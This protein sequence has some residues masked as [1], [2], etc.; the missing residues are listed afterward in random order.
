MCFALRFCPDPHQ[1][2]FSRKLILGSGKVLDHSH[3]CDSMLFR[4][5]WREPGVVQLPE[6]KPP[7]RPMDTQTLNFEDAMSPC[8]SS[9]PLSFC[10]LER[11]WV[12]ALHESTSLLNCTCLYNLAHFIQ[13]VRSFCSCVCIARVNRHYSYRR[14][15]LC[16]W[17]E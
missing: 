10:P 5:L 8:C 6:R 4:E 17:W 3:L 12:S 16:T 14:V 7:K 15:I 2:A 9:A 1:K 13:V 11:Q